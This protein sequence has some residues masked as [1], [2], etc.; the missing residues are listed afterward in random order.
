ML[1]RMNCLLAEK[2]GTMSRIVDYIVNRSNVP[3]QRSAQ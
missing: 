1:I 2:N 3:V